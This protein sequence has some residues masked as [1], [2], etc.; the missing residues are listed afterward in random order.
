MTKAEPRPRSAVASV[1]WS[2]LGLVGGM[3][4][5]TSILLRHEVGSPLGMFAVGGAVILVVGFTIRLRLYA[6]HRRKVRQDA[7]PRR[8][9]GLDTAAH[10]PH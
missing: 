4:G 1:W 6:L 10:S 2:L 3:M 9:A 5:A 8:E 7:T